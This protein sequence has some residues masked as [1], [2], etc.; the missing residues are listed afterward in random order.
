M[1]HKLTVDEMLP[2]PGLEDVGGGDLKTVGA[3][4][5]AGFRDQ[6]AVGLRPDEKV[7]DIGCGIGRVAIHLTQYLDEFRGRYEGF[8]VM[9]SHVDFCS[10]RITPSYPNFRFTHSDVRNDRYNPAG[11]I[12]ASSYRFP[13]D[14][15]TFDFAFATSVFTHLL[16][17]DAKRYLQETARVLR[18]RG[19]R[20]LA[21]FF[22]LDNEARAA[23]A[24]GK[25]SIGFPHRWASSC[26]VTNR[27][28]PEI[29][30]A[31]EHDFVRT[32]FHRAGL[33]ITGDIS[34][35]TWSGR[36]VPWGGFQDQIVAVR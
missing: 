22:L 23:V 35:G 15:G 7:L 11:R 1:N 27:E 36:S 33:R 34:W 17:D 5:A 3:A 6:P 18:R 9:K 16:P 26:Y 14:D 25:N 4:I 30:V 24:A 32:L 21:T 13:Y 20:F 31:Y 10:E 8:D 2:P 19:G 28:S 12:K 29:A